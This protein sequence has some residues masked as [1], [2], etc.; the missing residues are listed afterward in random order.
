MN[1]MNDERERATHRQGEAGGG[2]VETAGDDRTL[3]V[4]I[5]LNSEEIQNRRLTSPQCQLDS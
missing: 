2:A 3:M 4:L 5:K 1:L